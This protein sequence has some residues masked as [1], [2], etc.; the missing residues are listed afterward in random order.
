MLRGTMVEVQVDLAGG[1][2]YPP[3]TLAIAMVDLVATMVDLA[4]TMVDPID[5]SVYLATAMVSLIAA[6]VVYK[7]LVACNVLVLQ[8]VLVVDGFLVE[9]DRFFVDINRFLATTMVLATKDYLLLKDKFGKNTKT[10]QMTQ[11]RD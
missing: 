5:T 6:K 4:A 2:Q 9:F 3:G 7:T 11:M 10:N 8:K 1:H